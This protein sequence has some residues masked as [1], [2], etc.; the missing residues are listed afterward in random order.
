MIIDTCTILCV[1]CEIYTKECHLL[2]IAFHV[3]SIR[4]RLR[5]FMMSRARGDKSPVCCWSQYW[6]PGNAVSEL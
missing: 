5:G 1:T 3:M 4:L 6:E 2:T